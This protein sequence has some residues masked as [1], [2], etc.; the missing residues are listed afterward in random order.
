MDEIWGGDAQAWN[1]II[2]M[3]GAHASAVVHTVFYVQS[4]GWILELCDLDGVI[5]TGDWVSSFPIPHHRR[6]LE[7]LAVEFVD[8]ALS[9][10]RPSG[11]V[12]I[13]VRQFKGL[14]A[15]DLVSQTLRFSRSSLTSREVG[16]P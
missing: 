8:R 2:V 11:S 4:R 9:A 7:V 14:M 3:H 13:V 16:Q 12:A 6:C 5:R 10:Q 15:Q 1:S